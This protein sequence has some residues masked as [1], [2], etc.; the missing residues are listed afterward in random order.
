MMSKLR[1]ELWADEATAAEL[2][3]MPAEKF[4]AHLQLLEG[5]GFPKPS[6]WNG[7]RYVPAIRAFW[8][9]QAG[10]ELLVEAAPVHHQDEDGK[11]RWGT[12]D[13]ENHPGERRAT[14]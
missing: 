8:D 14:R 6:P 2:S 11:D 5:E 3:G 13:R 1:A 4:R 10:L 12:N 9:K 7:K